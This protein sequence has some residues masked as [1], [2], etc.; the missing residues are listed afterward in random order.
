MRNQHEQV[1]NLYRT[2]SG[3]YQRTA[4]LPTSNDNPNKLEE[5]VVTSSRVPMPLR[6]IGTSVSVITQQEITERGF[7]SLSDVLRTQPSMSVT[8]SG[9]AG[10]QTTLRI[11]GEEG[12]R[13]LV[14]LDGIDLSEHLHATGEHAI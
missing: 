2:G 14:L 8:N 7:N 6:Q 3:Q 12:F 9:G 13:T 11:R 10:Q 4:G 1:F 5:I